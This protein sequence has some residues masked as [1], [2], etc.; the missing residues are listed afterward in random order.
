MKFLNNLSKGKKQFLLKK[1][2]NYIGYIYF[3]F[4][5]DLS[6]KLQKNILSFLLHSSINNQ[7]DKISFNPLKIRNVVNH[8]FFNGNLMGSSIALFNVFSKLYLLFFNNN[9]VL[10]GKNYK[11]FKEF[12]Y[13]FHIYKSY[14]SLNYLNDWL[15]SWNELIFT[16]E[17]TVVPKKYRKK[18]KKKY[19]YKVKY[20][21]KNKRLGKIYNWLSKYANTIKNFSFESRLLLALLD[22][23]LNYKNSYLYNKKL[24]VYKKIFRI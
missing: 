4:F 16:I 3:F 18:L 19:L 14:N 5:K 2:V 20:L 11:Y 22:T 10:L 21:N 13:N 17:C 9:N 1:N 23:I 12:F 24:L 15:T 6:K 7:T 8:F